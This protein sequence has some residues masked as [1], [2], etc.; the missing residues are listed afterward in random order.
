M[1]AREI[2]ESFLG[3][4]RYAKR[5]GLTFRE[6]GNCHGNPGFLCLNHRGQ[7]RDRKQAAVLAETRVVAGHL[8]FG[9]HR[10]V[11]GTPIYITC[12]R[13]PLDTAV[14]GK[15]YLHAGEVGSMSDSAAAAHMEHHLSKTFKPTGFAKRLTGV[16]PNPRDPNALRS[17]ANSAIENLRT[18]FAVVGVVEQYAA[19]IDLVQR[20]L[21]PVL[22][23][24]RKFWDF[25]KA[26][27]ENSSVKST[28]SIIAL[29][30]ASFVTRFNSSLVDEWRIYDAALSISAALAKKY[31]VDLDQKVAIE[32]SSGPALPEFRHGARNHISH[33][34]SPELQGRSHADRPKEDPGQH[35]RSADGQLHRAR[36]EARQEQRRSERG[37]E[38]QKRRRLNRRYRRMHDPNK[39]Q[40]E[41]VT[42]NPRGG[43]PRDAVFKGMHKGVPI[44]SRRTRQASPLETDE[45]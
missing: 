28:S 17:S 10:L 40:G 8:W 31:G 1:L 32:H 11:Q 13:R 34:D 33:N 36:G 2:S 18:R 24:G 16:E 25:Q 29:L 21:D 9:M 38:A 37:D 15:L 22:L 44:V 27:R 6:T 19:F 4:R 43:V 42:V 45:P 30:G 41:L 3:R 5:C 26:K 14:S 20:T 39:R 35:W 7:V 23:L 12:V